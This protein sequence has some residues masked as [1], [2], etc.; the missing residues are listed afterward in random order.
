MSNLSKYPKIVQ[1]GMGVNISDWYLA[2]AVSML[3]QQGTVSGVALERVLACILQRGDPNGHI[4]RALSH[5]PFQGVVKEVLDAFYV[6][7]GV[8]KGL[9]TKSVPTFNIAPSSLLIS[10][11]ICANYAFVW[12]AKEGHPNPVSIN[13][14]E[15]ITMP[16][17]Y[18][19]T[20]AML[21]GVDRITMGAG[22]AIQIPEV[23]DCIANGRTAIY[24]VPVIGTKTTSHLMSFDPESFF[25]GKLP[26]I[27]RPEFIPIIASNLL[28]SI[29]MKKLPEGS[30]N[31][32]VVEEP[33]AGGHNAPPR[34]PIFNEQGEIQPIYGP[35]DEVDYAEIA[36]YGLP[37]WIGGAKASPEKLEWALSVGAQGIQVGSIF[38][39]C[40][41]SGMDP[42]IRQRIRELGFIGK[43]QI[44]TDMR[45]SPTGFPFKTVILDGT[46]SEQDVYSN[47]VRVCNHGALVSLYEK[48]DGTLGYRCAAEPL[49]SFAAKGGDIADTIGRG[50]ICNGLLSTAGLTSQG[51]ASIITLGDD[52]SFLPNLMVNAHSSYGAQDAI[53]YLL[54]VV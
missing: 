12:L 15:K 44:R 29:F 13:Y 8:A 19:I 11:V 42:D 14:L 33:S 23:L 51:E 39:L 6:E 41:E 34:K 17:I 43:L 7:R 5:F 25:G 20:G 4:R 37:F 53:N 32:F 40:E 16:H 47:R 9:R 31:G 28:A 27:K 1:G 10:L 18:A 54:G 46:I 50:C 24:R 30:V 35:R 21:A 48:A 22:I 2:R 45:I 52:Y 49:A 36:K 38:A 26:L 3:D